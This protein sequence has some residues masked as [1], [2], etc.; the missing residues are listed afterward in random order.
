M[1]R[2]VMALVCAACMTGMNAKSLVAFFSATGTTKVAAT[3]LAKQHNARLWEIEAAE[4]Y[5]MADLD[6]RNDQSR[7]SL[8]MKDPDERPMIKQCTDVTPY[9]PSGLEEPVRSYI[10]SVCDEWRQ[11]Y[12]R[13]GRVSEK[14]LSVTQMA[15]RHAA[16]QAVTVHGSS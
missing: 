14:D 13:S 16:Q 6:W 8:E 12:R 10:D 5:T 3:K 9:F 2:I 15:E 4:R 7:S 1:K 11:R